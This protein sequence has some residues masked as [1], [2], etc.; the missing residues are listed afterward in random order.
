MRQATIICRHGV[1]VA[2]RAS[3]CP[4]HL[5]TVNLRGDGS[6]HLLRHLVLQIENIV[7]GALKSIRPEVRSDRDINELPADPQA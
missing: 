5:G 4:L 3:T 1:D 6:H 7:Q 2:D